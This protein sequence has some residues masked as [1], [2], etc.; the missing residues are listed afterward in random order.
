[1]VPETSE[2]PS[3]DVN[4]GLRM[5]EKAHALQ[6][7]AN[8]FRTGGRVE[9]AYHAFFQ[10]G[11]LYARHREALNASLCFAQAAT[12]WNIHTGWQPLKYAATASERAAEQALLAQNYDYS[13][14]LYKEAALLYDRE[15]NSSAFSR[16]Y[17]KAHEVRRQVNWQGFTHCRTPAGVRVPQLGLRRL[18]FF[19]RWFFG[20][21]GKWVWGHGE[22]P[23]R[24][25]LVSLGVIFAGAVYYRFFGN[26]TFHTDIVTP[27]FGDALYFSVITFATVGYGDYL[28]L[29]LTRVVASV[30]S[31]AGITLFPL[32]M[33]SLTRRF[34]RI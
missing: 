7:E 1:M 28:P 16:C 29:G 13:L 31:I 8:G 24:T 11:E 22:R 2:K 26:L 27:D 34:L 15:G 4:D 25:L 23:F 17:E 32:F 18:A 5:L 30:Q 33:I 12:C 20:T 14:S 3:E 21:L 10:A 19:C 6:R 9:E